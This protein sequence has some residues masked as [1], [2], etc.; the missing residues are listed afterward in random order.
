MSGRSRFATLVGPLSGVALAL[1]AC[2]SQPARPPAAESSAPAAAAPAAPAASAPAAAPAPAA[3]APPAAPLPVNL[4]TLKGLSDSATFIAL[5][6]GYFV[7]QGLAINAVSFDTAAAMVAPLSAG[8]LDVGSGS[9][10]VGFYNAISRDIP[11]R[12]VADKGSQPPGFGFQAIVVRSDLADQVQDY[13]DL[14]GRKIGLVSRQS[15][16]GMVLDRALEKAGLGLADVDAIEM[17]Y[18]DMNVGLANRNLEAAVTW[19]PL[20]SRGVEQGIFVRWK[21]ADEIVPNNQS[22]VIIYAPQLIRE[23]PEAARRWMVAYTKG[24]RDYNDAFLHGKNRAAVVDILVKETGVGP[25]ALYD[26]MVPTGL[27]PNCSVHRQELTNDLK[28]FERQGAQP[29]LDLATIVDDSY[30]QHAVAV[31]GRYQ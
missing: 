29:G 24:L 12:I 9:P 6:Q 2:A 10:S 19:E 5:A 28:W 3:P 7:E 21:G 17:A 16:A 22:G 15:V 1:A 25:A 4:G 31:L 23:Q 8:Q 30:C 27:N 18:P 14:R 20:L 11:L 26:R 13:A